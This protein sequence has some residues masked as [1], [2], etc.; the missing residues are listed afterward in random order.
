VLGLIK[1][2]MLAGGLPEELVSLIV[3][4][5]QGVRAG[6]IGKDFFASGVKVTGQIKLEQFAE[7]FRVAYLHA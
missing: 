1:Q 4:M 7:E 5:G 2:G 6:I 3:E